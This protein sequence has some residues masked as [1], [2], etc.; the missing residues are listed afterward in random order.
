MTVLQGARPM[1][2]AIRVNPRVQPRGGAHS[3]TASRRR[4][5]SNP[6]RAGRRAQPFGALIALVLVALVVG[7]IYVAQ[8]IQVAATNYEID[9]LIAERDDLARQVQTMETSVL[10]WGTEATVLD[11]AQRIGLDQLETRIRLPAR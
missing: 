10:R 3:I 5:I 4:R 7:L 6:A 9:G 1:A 2:G 8:T 11:R